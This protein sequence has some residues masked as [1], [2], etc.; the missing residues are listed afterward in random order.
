MTMI[1]EE[2][3][4]A[5]LQRL[6]ATIETPDAGPAQVLVAARR[7][8]FRT[9]R[10]LRPDRSSQADRSARR[11]RWQVVV[12]VGIVLAAVIGIGLVVTRRGST[13]VSGQVFGVPTFSTP[14]APGQKEA[15][16]AVGNLPASPVTT[17]PAGSLAVPTDSAKI[18]KTGT[19]DLQVGKGQLSSTVDQLTSLVG[20]L[21]G[22]VA[23]AST[24]EGS[25]APT[26]DMT[27]RVPVGQFETLLDRTREM[28][29]ALSQTTSGQDV[30]ASYVNLAAQIQAL[31][32]TQA[33]FEQIL[34]KATDIGDILDVEQQL[35]TVQT[36][37]DQ[38]QGQ[39]NLLADQASFSTLTV[40]LTETGSSS[41]VP[42]PPPQGLSLA[43]AHARHSFAHGIEDVVGASGGV[44]V[45]VLFAGLLLLAGRLTWPLIRRRLV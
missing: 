40:Q 35:S 28:G 1:D 10:R 23:D 33:Q 9:P 24:T 45:F 16:G 14:A 31:D 26:G 20:G 38:L 7:A 27:L 8:L 41:P 43:W 25:G 39:E 11:L 44:L 34:S 32:D 22:Y 17:V 42:P 36:Q 13:T 18:V 21:G 5:A 6:G 2:W 15:T 29:R 30:T 3:L 12:A 4:D 37:I 19:L